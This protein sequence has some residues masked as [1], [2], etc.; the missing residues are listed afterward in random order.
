[1]KVC[2]SVRLKTA[3]RASSP[4]AENCCA[5]AR[6]KVRAVRARIEICSPLGGQTRGSCCSTCD[7]SRG[8]GLYPDTTQYVS[9]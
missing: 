1:M 6:V 3:R 5:P 7:T 8:L 2:M 9:R 4:N